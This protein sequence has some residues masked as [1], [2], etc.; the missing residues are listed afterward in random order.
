MHV[1]H[2][3]CQVV[4]ARNE[5]TCLLNVICKHEFTCLKHSSS[6][7]LSR[8]VYAFISAF[9]LTL[10]I[11]QSLFLRQQLFFIQFLLNMFHHSLFLV[12]ESLLNCEKSIIH[13]VSQQNTYTFE[14][15]VFWQDFLCI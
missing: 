15:K 10:E 13:R 4:N 5:S 2:I 1:F 11:L 6:D 14:L 3:A 7:T 12:V 8:W 9:H